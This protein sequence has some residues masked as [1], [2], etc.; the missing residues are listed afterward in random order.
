MAYS[1]IRALDNLSVREWNSVTDD[2][3]KTINFCQRVGLLHTYPAVFCPKKHTNWYLGSCS[4]SI[5]RCKWRCR[6]CNGSAS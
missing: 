3:E 5:D 2:L 1:P 6:I 4:K